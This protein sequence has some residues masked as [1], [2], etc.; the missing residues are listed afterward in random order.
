MYSQMELG[1]IPAKRLKIGRI[2]ENE[3]CVLMRRRAG[4]TQRQVGKDLG[5]CRW[6]INQMESGKVDCTPLTTYWN[7]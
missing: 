2:T 4:Y 1:S 6:W 7:A 3:R 5:F